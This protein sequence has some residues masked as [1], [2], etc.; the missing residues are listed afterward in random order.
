MTSKSDKTV[1][2]NVPPITLA[3]G[4][5]GA[6]GVAHLGVIEELEKAG[7]TIERIVGVSSGS[8][9]G[10]MYVFDSD[11]IAAQ[12]RA[13]DFLLS[14]GFQRHQEI[15]FGVSSGGGDDTSGGYF[16]WYGR[17]KDYLRGNRL[18]HR[19][20]TRQSL[21]PGIIV[22]DVVDQLLPKADIAEAQIPFSVVAVDL[23]SGHSVIV[24]K[25][26]VREAVRASS[27][28]PGIWP[29]VEFDGMLLCDIGVFY[30]LPTTLARSYA[31]ACLVAVEVSSDT[32]PLTSCDTALDVLMRIDDI[33]E[34][35]FRKHVR[36]AA[37]F[38]IDPQVD[39]EWF[40]FSSSKEVINAGREAA[41]KAI[42]RIVAEFD[43][44][45]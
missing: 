23:L 9:A 10:A 37:D 27:S 22:Q 29:P 1:A 26:P 31:P 36:D 20:S 38:V 7:F 25:G 8:L 28:L 44:K 32:K 33:G 6:R 3:L 39:V 14:D 16:S 19:I 13:I 30:S 2:E 42:P 12:K 4:G 15:L 21:L 34:T 17:V 24:E 43:N 5:G 40:D 11:V 18:F 41:R 45:K 35:L